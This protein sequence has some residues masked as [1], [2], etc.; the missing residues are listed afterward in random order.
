MEF[1]N[2]IN[3]MMELMPLFK[4]LVIAIV[5]AMLWTIDIFMKIGHV[6][7]TGQELGEFK[8]LLAL[9]SVTGFLLWLF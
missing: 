4:L 1:I 7:I 2:H 3:Y 5:F 8:R 9:G 6:M